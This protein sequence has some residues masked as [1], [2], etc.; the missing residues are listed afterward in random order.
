M[1]A[2]SRRKSRRRSAQTLLELVAATT[3]LAITLVPALRIMRDSLSISR[4][5]ELANQMSSFC[6]SRLE[7]QMAATSASW[8]TTNFNGD[9][10]SE[11]YPSLNY[12]VTRNDTTASGGIPDA[13][14]VINCVVWDDQNGNNSLDAGEPNVNYST[15]IGNFASYSDA[16]SS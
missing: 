6:V 13:L 11:G 2:N 9:Y 1:F 12:S 16:A 3:I 4:E 14:M 8:S 5:I 7:S 10:T 15:K